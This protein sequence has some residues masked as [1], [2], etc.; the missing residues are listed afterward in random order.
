MPAVA[1]PVH[2]IIAAHSG[3]RRLTGGIDIGDENLVG[4]IETAAEIVEQV[5]KAAVAVRLHDGDQ[6]VGAAQHAA[7]LQGG[8]DFHRVMPVIVDHGHAAADSLGLEAPA[9]PAEAVKGRRDAVGK[10]THLQRHRDR[11][12]AVLDIM[13]AKH[14]EAHARHHLEPAGSAV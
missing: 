5:G 4:V 9:D 8:A 14:R 1:Q 2:K 6:L 13:L 10:D 7:C 3:D 11:G 12:E